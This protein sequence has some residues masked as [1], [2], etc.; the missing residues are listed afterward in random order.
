[1]RKLVFA[2]I[3]LV[4]VVMNVLARQEQP[5]I[6]YGKPEEL[7]GITKIF[8][9][10]GTDLKARESIVEEIKKKLPNLTITESSDDAEVILIYSQSERPR[11]VD[12][13][14]SRPII[15]GGGMVVRPLSNN[16]VRLLMSHKTTKKNIFQSDVSEK[17]AREFV[18]AYAK[19]NGETK[20]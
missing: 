15:A 17:F 11:I 4:L 8:V 18:K 3:T 19:A 20:K 7:K 12:G 9:D 13:T 1:M 2:V 10:A 16:K 5:A 6:E 14:S